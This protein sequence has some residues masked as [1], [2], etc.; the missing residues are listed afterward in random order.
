MNVTGL[1]AAIVTKGERTSL[2]YSIVSGDT[3]DDLTVH[4][5]LNCKLSV[6]NVATIQRSLAFFIDMTRRAIDASVRDDSSLFIMSGSNNGMSEAAARMTLIALRKDVRRLAPEFEA[7]LFDGYQGKGALILMKHIE[8]CHLMIATVLAGQK[9]KKLSRGSLDFVNDDALFNASEYA[10]MG[11]SIAQGIDHV[12]GDDGTARQIADMYVDT[13]HFEK[14]PTL[15]FLKIIDPI[16]SLQ[17]L[18]NDIPKREAFG[19]RIRQRIGIKGNFALKFRSDPLTPPLTD[20]L[21]AYMADALDKK[22]GDAPGIV[23][24]K[25]PS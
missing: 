25:M 5:N 20:P 3:K 14:N 11:K 7:D 8:F 18:A 21:A 17:A 15:K 10:A 1:T 16:E 6:N 2:D 19:K 4:E 23:L 13:H 24:A 12:R 22:T 9:G